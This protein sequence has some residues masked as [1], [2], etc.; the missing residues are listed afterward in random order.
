[1]TFFNNTTET[2][3]TD[4]TYISSPDSPP[5]G[6]PGMT[7]YLA[8]ANAGYFADILGSSMLPAGVESKGH[9]VISSIDD[10]PLPQV[11]AKTYNVDEHGGTFGQSLKTFS[12]DELIYEGETGYIAGVSNS[13][14]KFSGFRTNVGVLN[15]ADQ[16]TAIVDILIYDD[17]GQI[18]GSVLG[19]N[20]GPGVFVQDNVFAFAYLANTD[21][22]GS[23]EIVVRSGG[24]I[25]VY[26]SLIDNK[27]QD[28]ILIPAS[29]AIQ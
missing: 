6:I 19:L 20:V 11:V 8:S 28:A 26:A 14:D 10:S 15:V 9:L 29:V 22:N 13:S 18:A 17:Q 3:S 7:L 24:P 2:M 23:I 25:A 4:V 16:Q 27:T 1:V 12:E 5:I 21:M